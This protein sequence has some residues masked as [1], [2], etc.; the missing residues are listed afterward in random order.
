LSLNIEGRWALLSD[1]SERE[2][3]YAQSP[4]RRK[5][6]VFRHVNPQVGAGLLY[7]LFS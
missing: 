1:I 5:R 7:Y 2:F 6:V 4:T 3:L